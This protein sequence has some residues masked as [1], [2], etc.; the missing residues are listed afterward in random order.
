MRV[1][2]AVRVKVCF[3]KNIAKRGKSI[4]YSFMGILLGE[5]SLDFFRCYP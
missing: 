5:R 1:E 3:Y 2:I 4:I